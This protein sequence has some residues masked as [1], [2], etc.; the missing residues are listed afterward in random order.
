MDLSGILSVAIPIFT[1]VLMEVVLSVD[2]AAALAIIV[3][4]L[5][6][7]EE[8]VKALRYGIIGAYVF[9]GLALVLASLLIKIAFLKLLG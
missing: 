1:I 3:R 4:M 6:T 5:P 2:N 7:Q 8:R 9:R